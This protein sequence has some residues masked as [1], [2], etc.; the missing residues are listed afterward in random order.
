MKK[1]LF[2]FFTLLIVVAIISICI[3]Y[4]QPTKIHN[5]KHK[6]KYIPNIIYPKDIS[7]K[8]KPT[9]FDKYSIDKFL[10]S[11]A[12]KIYGN[13]ETPIYV[14]DNFFS[15]EDCEELIADTIKK[16]ELIESPLTRY[17]PDEPNFRTSKTAMFK[18]NKLHNYIENKILQQTQIKEN[19]PEMGQIQYY[20]VGNEFKAHWDFFDPDIDWTFLNNGQRTWTCMVYLNDVLDGGETFFTNLNQKIK[21]KKG[22]AV[23]WCNLFDD[24][25]LNRETMHAGLPIKDGEKW[26]ITKWFLNKIS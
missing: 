17:N 8:Y 7:N 26:I 11:K 23:I 19:I 3:Y 4:N 1:L 24:G 2:I 16:N 9:P 10:R 22:R 18:D 6:E 21:P 5:K 25:T 12:T 13:E 15:D 20:K 14:I